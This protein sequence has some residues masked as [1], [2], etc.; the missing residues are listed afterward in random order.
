MGMHSSITCFWKKFDDHLTC[1]AADCTGSFLLIGNSVGIIR[2]IDIHD[3]QRAK[4]VDSIKLHDCNKEITAV[5]FNDEY[6]GALI[7]K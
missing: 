7:S 2:L 4:L 5:A 6:Q 3:C 1:V